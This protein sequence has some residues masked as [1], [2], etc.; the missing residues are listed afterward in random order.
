V[1]L[2]VP[3]TDVLLWK[4]N[5]PGVR[6]QKLRQALPYSLEDDVAQDVDSLHFAM[7]GT[8]DE[9]E[10]NVAVAARQLMDEWLNPL[11]EHGIEP[12]AIYPE[13]F[14]VPEPSDENPGWTILLDDE[15]I[16]ARTGPQ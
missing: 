16:L 5:V 9:G 1:V 3:G 4:A 11:R 10:R 13:M 15:L 6:G 14:G 8:T 12:D 2:L 7:G